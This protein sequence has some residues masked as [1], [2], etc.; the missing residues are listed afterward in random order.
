[1]DNRN[2]ELLLRLRVM[3]RL[4]TER[5]EEFDDMIDE[6]DAYCYTLRMYAEWMVGSVGP[7]YSAHSKFVRLKDAFLT[8]EVLL[9]LDVESVEEYVTS[10]LHSQIERFRSDVGELVE[11]LEE[12]M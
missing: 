5:L 3:D 2:E 11:T 6:L 7:G 8:F 9:T 10:N 12:V 1:M 4:L